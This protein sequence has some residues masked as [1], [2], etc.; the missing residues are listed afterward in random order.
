M[1]SWNRDFYAM[2]VEE[3]NGLCWRVASIVDSVNA[4]LVNIALEEFVMGGLQDTAKGV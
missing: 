3:V 4:Y 2:L 1:I